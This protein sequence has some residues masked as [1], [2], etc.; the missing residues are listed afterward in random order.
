[1]A[2]AGREREERIAVE[3]VAM[4]GVSGP[5][6]VGVM[7][8]EQS[9]AAAGFGDAMEFS[10]E[11][12]DVGDMFDNVIADD[13]IELG[14]RERIREKPE[15]MDHVGGGFGAD[16]E[17]DGT[18]IFVAATADVEDLHGGHRHHGMPSA[19][20]ERIQALLKAG[21]GLRFALPDDKSPPS[22]LSE[23]PEVA[24]IT[25][26]I[27]GQLWAPIIRMSQGDVSVGATLML[28]P[29]ATSN[30]D[31]L[32]EPGKD[33]IRLSRQAGYVKP[34]TETQAMDHA[35]HNQFGGRVAGADEPHILR[36]AGGRQSISAHPDPSD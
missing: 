29:E 23:L 1:M 15:V 30:F 28:M 13:E 9:D 2:I 35:P 27:A 36:S 33:Q 10:H 22:E 3:V 26:H 6:G 21:G 18:G 8:R 19:N 4:R 24:L 34:E 20:E 12:H 5:I 11:T 16:V 7:R 31:D 14:V 25:S 17:A 32:G